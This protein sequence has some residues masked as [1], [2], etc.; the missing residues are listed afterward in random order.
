MKKNISILLVSLLTLAMIAGCAPAQPAAPAATGTGAPQAAAAAGAIRRDNLTIATHREPSSLL[1]FG[2]ND[3]G[4]SP[5]TSLI[6]D[7]LLR[8][9]DDMELIPHLAT[10]WEMVDETHFRFALRNDVY[11]HN[12]ARLTAADVLYSLSRAATAPATSTIFGVI[13]AD[14][15][16]IE[17]DF[18]IV[19]ALHRPHAPFLNTMT[20]ATSGVVNKEAIQADPDEYAENP[21]GTGPFMFGSWAPGDN[22]VLLAND[23]WWGGDINVGSL[24]LRLIPENVTRAIEVETGGADVALIVMSDVAVLQDA[25]NVNVIE[26]DILNV[27]F[28]SF[29]A[30]RAPFDDRYVRQAISS[31]INTEAI[32][33]NTT[34]GLGSQSYSAIAPDVWGYYNA[35][36]PFSFNVERARELLAQ[37]SVP[38][39]FS[40]TI[41]TSGVPTAA[42]MIQ[43]FLSEI[44]IDVEIQAVD[45]ASWLDAVV[46]GRQDMYIGGWTVASADAH[47]GFRAF[48]SQYHGPGGNR[49][50]Y[51]NTE[52]DALIDAGA[53]EMDPVRRAEIYREIQEILAYE[54]IYVHLQ[55]GQM[56]VAHCDSIEGLSVSPGQTVWFQDI[57]FN[58]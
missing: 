29:N 26:Q 28:L 19:I 9:S 24:N 5:I 16:V 38:E 27:S 25:P 4:T 7:T 35:G 49:S 44:N 12:G 36:N 10:S 47:D 17:D 53:I 22:M 31:A 45:F 3:T 14:N 56:F 2:A 43:A 18:N 55:V 40:T 41:I 54:A 32:V 6:Y 57:A 37:S 48:H 34:F 52:L 42:E 11:F 58:R 30:S 33:R 15:S 20:L 46:T 13:D 21:V 23:N 1:P 39:G 51:S 8:F 50:F